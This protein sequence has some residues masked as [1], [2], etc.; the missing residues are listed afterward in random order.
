MKAAKGVHFIPFSQCPPTTVRKDCIYYS[1]PALVVPKAFE[2]LHCCEVLP[3]NFCYSTL[4]ADLQYSTNIFYSTFEWLEI[5]HYNDNNRMNILII[6]CLRL[7]SV[8][9]IANLTWSQWIH[10]ANSSFWSKLLFLPNKVMYHAHS[11]STHKHILINLNY[12]R[13]GY[14]EG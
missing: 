11:L 13:T 9:C 8:V 1:T 14:Q 2:N 5:L 6:L 4:F 10:Q 7:I 12:N 3:C